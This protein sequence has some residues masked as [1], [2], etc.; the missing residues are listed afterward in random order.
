MELELVTV[1]TELLLGF[2]LDSN[3]ADI[4]RILASEGVNVLRCS[5]VHDD[6]DAIRAVVTDGLRRSGFVIVTG[7][8]GPTRDDITKKVVSEI[9]DAPLELDSEYLERLRRRFAKFGGGP[10]P[11]SNR[12]QAEVPRGAEMLPNPRGTAPGLWIDG[13]PGTIVLLPGIPEEMRGILVGAVVPRLRS[14]APDEAGGQPVTR[15]LV[16][17][18]TGISES[19]L[20][21]TIGE[22]EG[23]MD[24]VSL[25]YLPG[26]DGTDLRLTVWRALAEEA[27]STLERA[28]AELRPALGEN[29][30]GEGNVELTEVLLQRLRLAGWRLSVAESC[31]GGLIGARL[32]AVPGSSDVFSG[33]VVCYGNES[34]VRDLEVAEELLVEEGAVSTAV[35]EAM[36]TGVCS[37]F[38]TEAG[39]A[40]TGIAGPGGGTTEKPVGT[41]C[42]A[43]Q[44]GE[45]TV[46]VRRWFPGGRE[47]VRHRSAQAALDLLRRSLHS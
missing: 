8:L 13:E 43:A 39:V 12:S 18:T 31:T 40:V 45:R 34:K 38:E 15:S 33:G 28:A 25:A 9:Y 42:L 44:A 14:L 17:R 29:L 19:K 16:L 10:M 23:A 2:T 24:G 27:T 11:E 1:G 6:E 20:A 5:T 46:S 4:G 47:E 21:D 37:R 36:V 22:L 41:A 32:T 3:A 30:Y 7:G 35:A 26:V